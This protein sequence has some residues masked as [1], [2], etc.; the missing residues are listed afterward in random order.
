MPP[1]FAGAL[2]QRD[3]HILREL[4]GNSDIKKPKARQPIATANPGQYVPK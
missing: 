3:E 4:P 2:R 1:Q